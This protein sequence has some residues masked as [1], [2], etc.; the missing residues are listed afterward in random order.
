MPIDSHATGANLR[1]AMPLAASSPWPATSPT[2]SATCPSG[3][4]CAWYQSPPTRTALSAG[5]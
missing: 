1:C 3:S 5:R 4:V 2:A